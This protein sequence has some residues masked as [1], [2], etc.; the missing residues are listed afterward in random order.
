MSS[1]HL[2]DQASLEMLVAVLLDENESC[3]PTDPKLFEH[4][5]KGDE[6]EA[7]FPILRHSDNWANIKEV[8]ENARFVQDQIVIEDSLTISISKKKSAF[9]VHL[10]KPHEPVQLPE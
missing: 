10:N 6:D 2:V 8:N 1:L 5:D 3:A 7:S 9:C 4:I